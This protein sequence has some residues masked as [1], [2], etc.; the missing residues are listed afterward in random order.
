MV[1]NAITFNGPDHGVSVMGKNMELVFDKQLKHLPLPV[2][3]VCYSYLILS[4][5]G[6]IV[7]FCRNQNLPS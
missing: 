2:T 3:E 1:Q 4:I 5:F 6:L 7:I